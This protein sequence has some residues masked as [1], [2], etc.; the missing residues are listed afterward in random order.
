M[1]HESKRHALTSVSVNLSAIQHNVREILR[2]THGLP[3]MAVVKANAYGHGIVPVAKTALNAGCASLAVVRIEEALELRRA[4]IQKPIVV[5]SYVSR[6]ISRDV[7]ARAIADSIDLVVYDLETAHLLSVLGRRQKKTVRVHLKIDTG[8]TRVGVL[9]QAFM[10]FFTAITKLPRIQI[11]G[12]FTHFA[13]SE[14]PKSRVTK[15]QIQAF[16]KVK[17]AIVRKGKKLPAFHAAS[18]AALMAHKD[19]WFDAGRLGIA[20]YGLWPS[21]EMQRR[22]SKNI[23]LAPALSWHTKILQVKEVPK[24]TRVSYDGTYTTKRASKIAALPVGY[25]DGLPRA[26]SNV[27]SVL[28]HGK[29][30]PIRGRI[31][32]NLTMIDVTNIPAAHVGS[33]VT[34]LGRDGREEISAEELAEQDHTINYEIVTRINWEL[35]RFYS[36][37]K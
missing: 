2:V 4:R 31:C 12:I 28:V 6:A 35:P 25:A 21:A 27:G 30:A 8:T 15:K 1:T 19:S 10:D 5:L 32:M 11:A 18:S 20:L 3:L 7:L 9:P 22:L 16:Q 17:R 24:G 34:L 13:E 29:R 26:L 37:T 33:T 23:R 14:N 36:K